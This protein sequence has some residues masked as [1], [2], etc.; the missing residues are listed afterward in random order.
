MEHGNSWQSRTV[1]V[2]AAFAI[3]MPLALRTKPGLPSEPNVR[4]FE[5]PI[6]PQ[7]TIPVPFTQTPDVATPIPTVQSGRYFH[8]STEG[9]LPAVARPDLLA[10][11]D[12]GYSAVL[13][14]PGIYLVWS[15][16]SENHRYYFTLDGSSDLFVRIKEIIDNNLFA[17]R[18]LDESNPLLGAAW[19]GVKT[20]GGG[21]GA[22]GCGI[23]VGV[24][25]ETPPLAALFGTCTLAGIGLAGDSIDEFI[26][27]FNSVRAY[28]NRT[29]ADLLA[30]EGIVR[31]MQSAPNQ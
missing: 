7:N 25:W 16:D 27:V 26:G 6:P 8:E 30:I 4:Q 2:V 17:R 10:E 19:A 15:V 20:L 14:Q 11:E 21:L 13:G 9:L 1:L 29:E 24:T 18:M 23:A 28:E 22:A 12:F 5:T 3:A 31:E